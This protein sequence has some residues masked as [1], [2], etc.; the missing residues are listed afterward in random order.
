M[1][2]L[3]KVIK[4][5]LY[6]LLV[7]KKTIVGAIIILGFGIIFG[8]A[9]RMMSNNEALS[10]M[11]N[12]NFHPLT[13]AVVIVA[14]ILNLILP[15]FCI[16]AISNMFTSDYSDGTMKMLLIRPLSRTKVFFAKYITAFIYVVI[17]LLYTYIVGLASGFV[18]FDS[19]N[20]L[21]EFSR[22]G[23]TIDISYLA[24]IGKTFTFIGL[25]S[26]VFLSLVA[27][28]TMISTFFDSAA[29]VNGFAIVFIVLS[30]I[31]SQLPVK[32]TEY[33]FNSSYLI[34]GYSIAWTDYDWSDISK[35]I[36]LLL[37]YTLV[38]TIA[39]YFRFKKRDMVL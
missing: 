4:W 26:L 9:F 18:F 6:K 14:D 22:G 36:Y 19:S 8:F 13:Y 24:Y 3:L 15:V 21:F 5:E 11:G 17:I 12:F 34:V 35:T 10:E 16:L 37:A 23:G 32:F 39:G 2:I 29:A 31:L 7:Q 38:F 1:R 30:G 27:M 33:I 25:T 20:P 28:A